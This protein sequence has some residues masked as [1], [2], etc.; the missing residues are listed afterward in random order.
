M[1]AFPH[2]LSCLHL[3]KLN[4]SELRDLRKRRLCCLIAS[5]HITPGKAWNV[6]NKMK[7]NAFTQQQSFVEVL[8]ILVSTLALIKTEIK[9]QST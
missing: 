3:P 2:R 6:N 7:R 9:E 1:V 5:L 4:S 8:V